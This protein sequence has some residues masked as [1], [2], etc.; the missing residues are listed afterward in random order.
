MNMIC[1]RGS[2]TS[3][4]SD[5]PFECSSVEDVV[6]TFGHMCSDPCGASRLSE[7]ELAE[8]ERCVLFGIKPSPEKVR[9]WRPRPFRVLQERGTQLTIPNM[10]HYWRNGHLYDTSPVLTGMVTFCSEEPL[11]I[12]GASTPVFMYDVSYPDGNRERVFNFLRLP[13]HIGTRVRTHAG[14]IAEIVTE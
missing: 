4:K 1:L 12:Q 13:V 10:L 2:L 5:V 8:A 14:G 9:L 6:W 7:D 11:K 3:R